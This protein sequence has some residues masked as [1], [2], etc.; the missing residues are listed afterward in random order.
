MIAIPACAEYNSKSNCSR[1]MHIG[2][3]WRAWRFVGQRVELD[4][5]TYRH[6]PLI[7]SQTLSICIKAIWLAV[8]SSVLCVSRRRSLQ[9]ALVWTAS[10]VSNVSAR[11]QAGTCVVYTSNFLYTILITFAWAVELDNLHWL[12]C[13]VW[14]LVDLSETLGMLIVS[15]FSSDWRLGRKS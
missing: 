9:P 14:L 7:S 5:H 3:L 8:H 4:Y 10:D 6:S 15:S 12:L 1:I 2:E 11:D 13:Q